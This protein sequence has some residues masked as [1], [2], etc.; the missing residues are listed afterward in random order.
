MKKKLSSILAVIGC[1]LTVITACNEKD[2]CMETP[3]ITKHVTFSTS[4]NDSALVLMTRA[5]SPVVPFPLRTKMRSEKGDSMLM[6]VKGEPFFTRRCDNSS[7]GR[8]TRGTQITSGKV[9]SFGVSASAYPSDQSYTTNGQG[10]FFYD[11]EATAGVATDYQWPTANQ[12]MSFF[13]YFPYDNASF[14]LS[15]SA[16]ENGSPTYSYTVPADIARQV[17]VMTAQV[18]DMNGGKQATCNL[19]FSH[20]CAAIRV[21]FSNEREETVTIE[22]LSILGVK[23]SGT[24]QDGAW[25]LTNSVNSSNTHPFT[26]TLDTNANEVGGGEQADLTGTSDIFLMLPQTLP[27]GAKLVVETDN[28]TYEANITGTWAAGNTYTYSVTLTDNFDY[29][30]NVTAPEAYTHEGGTKT[31]SIQSYKISDTGL[32][33][34]NVGWQMTFSTDDGDTFTS[35]KPSWLTT[36][37]DTGSGSVT[38]TACNATVTPTEK[39]TETITATSLLRDMEEVQDYDLSTKGGTSLM[40]TAN[41]YMVNAPGTYRFPL[42]YG[43]SIKNGAINTQAYN[44]QTGTTNYVFVNHNNVDITNPWLK[45]NGA[46]PD[47]AVLLWQDADGLVSSVDID[48]DYMTFSIN[49]ENIDGGNAVIAARM[50]ETIVWSW[51]IWVTPDTYEETITTGD[52]ETAPANLGWTDEEEI[53]VSNYPSRR[54]MVKVTQNGVNGKEH[55]FTVRQKRED[56]TDIR[57]SGWGYCTY[58][59]WGRKDPEFSN[60]RREL[61]TD[62]NGN[63]VTMSRL[64]ETVSRGKVIQ[65]PMTVYTDS[66]R[67]SAY[68]PGMYDWNAYSETDKSVKTIYDPCPPGFCVPPLDWLK[69]VVVLDGYTTLTTTIQVGAGTYSAGRKMDNSGNLY[70]PMK[71]R[72][73]PVYNY[74]DERRWSVMT[75]YSNPLYAGYYWISNMAEILT[76]YNITL[77]WCLFVDG[78]SFFGG[79]LESPTG[80]TVKPI[81]ESD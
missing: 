20:H 7:A 58:Y 14:T 57:Y 31:I 48:G 22:R 13:A 68:S 39:T 21:L 18:T 73:A 75:T 4:C 26:L 60:S 10:N 59:Q 66:L 70:F 19:P 29:I 11:I 72:R 51:H 3:R 27:E 77:S 55:I 2:D 16:T 33:T 9:T 25:T 42:V 46:A 52:Y 76:Q 5:D 34:K 56:I 78:S 50:G 49:N 64:Q 45:N 1:F 74:E 80:C 28:D 23:Y 79:K 63:T 30:L 62:I 44:I 6:T 38:F 61:I 37:A 35:E 81:R 24:L 43:N 40:N 71:G 8:E 41:C 54:C 12:K 36:T 53:T 32:E 17:D 47:N 65:T 69:T 67:S 15:S